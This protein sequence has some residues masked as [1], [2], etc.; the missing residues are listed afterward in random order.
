MGK[1]AIACPV[2]CEPDEKWQAEGRAV[3]MSTRDGRLSVQN[4]FLSW[5]MVSTPGKTPANCLNCG[6]CLTP[7]QKFCSQCGQ[8][9]SIGRIT[10]HEVWHDIIHYFTHADKG[11]FHLLA[12]LAKR[13]GMVAKEYMEGRRKAY[14]K[15]INFFLIVAGIL[16]IM[17]STFYRTTHDS[18]NQ[19]RAAAAR[20]QDPAMAQKLLQMADRAEKV[21]LVVGKY[22][23]V[24][25][26][27]ATPLF[28]FFLWLFYKK[29]R[30]SYMEHLVA[31]LFFVPFIMLFYALLFVPLLSVAGTGPAM[32]I[33]LSVFFLFDI[34]YRGIAYY[35]F[36]GRKGALYRVKA[37]G[38]S[39][40]TMLIW[41]GITYFG[42]RYYI[43][44][45]F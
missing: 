22:S 24:I 9:A 25:N 7:E 23:N 29:G 32:Y 35:G 41:L 12:A 39:L 18:A 33:L 42:I 44:H 31:N 40:L 4:G 34:I 27:M 10:L 2:L 17:T 11:I 16:V 8:Q 19:I 43:T 6:H 5:C 13:P 36:M 28:A 14:F 15:P 1:R 38:A 21:N 26:M 30:Y 3:G 37:F 45:G 20:V